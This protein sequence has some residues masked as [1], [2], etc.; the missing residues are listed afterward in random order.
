MAQLNV[1]YDR[2]V[3]GDSYFLEV[4]INPP[5]ATTAG[6]LV[7]S[8]VINTSDEDIAR[9][10]S[11]QDL[12][13]IP[14]ATTELVWF[15]ADAYTDTPLAGD[16]LRLDTIPDA[17]EYLGLTAPL[18]FEIYAVTGTLSVLEIEAVTPFICGF[19]GTMTYTIYQGFPAGAVRC[20]QTSQRVTIRR[21]EQD[22]P[23]HPLYVRRNEAVAL[24][25]SA[26]VLLNKYESLRAEAASLVTEVNIEEESFT[27]NPIT[28]AYI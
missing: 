28:E 20:T 16:T 21:Y 11:Q 19:T 27:P 15:Q 1:T 2:Q 6:D 10:A 22:T 26:V 7:K 12:I 23:G 17:W 25:P 5:P 18:D 13:D 4:T 24:Y 14:E 3:L 8:L 9:F